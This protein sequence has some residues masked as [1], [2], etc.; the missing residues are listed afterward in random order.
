[1]TQ[2]YPLSNAQMKLP[3]PKPKPESLRCLNC[4]HKVEG[5]ALF[6]GPICQDIAKY[7]RYHRGCLMD[8]RYKKEDV[9][10]A[11]LQR[12]ALICGGGYNKKERFLSKS[13]RTKVLKRDKQK[14]VL[15][16]ATDNLEIDH[17]DGSSD[18]LSNLQ[19]L[20]N[21]CHTEKSLSS[22]ELVDEKHPYFEFV[23]AMAKYLNQRVMSKKPLLLVDDHEVWCKTWKQVKKARTIY[24]TSIQPSN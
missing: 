6:C 8:G 13:V 23:N 3:T 9:K 2:V 11:L 16:G 21:A 7:V 4:G 18:D 1:M 24:W 19:V 10:I 17:I 12:R 14:C 20:C 22:I 5:D 15:C